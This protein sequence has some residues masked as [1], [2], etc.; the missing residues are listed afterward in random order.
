MRLAC[1]IVESGKLAEYGQSLSRKIERGDRL[2]KTHRTV[3]RNTAYR[4]S[5]FSIRERHNERKNEVY[6]NPDIVPGRSGL[7]IHFKQCEGTYAQMFDRLTVD[8][9]I[10]TRGLKTDAKVFDEMVFDVNSAY[11]D[12]LGGYEFAA[13]FFKVAY[14]LAVKEVGS[15]AYILS[16]VMH[17]DE[18]NRALSEELGRDVFHYHLHVTYVPIV[19]KEIRYTKRAKPELRGKV[20]ETIRQVS[21]SKKWKSEK[22]KDEHG[23]EER[24]NGKAVL[25][26]SYSLLQDRFFQHMKDAG[27]EGFERGVKGSTAQ[28]LSVLDYKIQ[29]DEQRVSELDNQVSNRQNDL[30][31]L[32]RELGAVEQIRLDNRELDGLGKKTMLGEVKLPQDEFGKLVAQAK[33]AVSL[34]HEFSRL[35]QQVGQLQS[36]LAY[37]GEKYDALY[38]RTR[39]YREAAKL[40]P[41]KVEN[42][43]V[44]ILRQHRAA[45]RARRQQRG[46]KSRE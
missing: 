38:D 5:E 29:Q 16:A 19:E 43:L 34:G 12:R 32:K 2:G 44:D 27:F 4:K 6:S 22:A 3:V 30:N 10:S 41:E 13:E 1:G 9:V 14:E 23:N 31:E 20:K 21:H 25:I 37:T 46:D 11:F 15:E 35:Q 17:A 39:T 26:P 40:Q 45:R 36:Q 7:N 18:R 33:R 8:R 42:W 24:E 28:H